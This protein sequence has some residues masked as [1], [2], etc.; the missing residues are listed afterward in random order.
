[1]HKKFLQTLRVK[2][3]MRVCLPLLMKVA[4]ALLSLAPQKTYSACAVNTVTAVDGGG[5]T[6]AL[7]APGANILYACCQGS[8]GADC[9]VY[10]E[11]LDCAITALCLCT[12]ATPSYPIYRSCP[13]S[14]TPYIPGPC[15][16]PAP[17][18][19]PTAPTTGL[20]STTRPS[21][22]P[23]RIPSTTPTD[24]PSSEPTNGPTV[25]PS[26]ALSA[27]SS[28][29]QSWWPSNS[30]SLEP[31]DTPTSLPSY[32][33]TFTG[34]PTYLPSTLA[35]GSGAPSNSP[36]DSPTV[37]GGV[38]AGGAA[39][40]VTLVCLV[41]KKLGWW[42]GED[43]KC[44]PCRRKK[45]HKNVDN[46]DAFSESLASS[47]PQSVRS[48][49]YNSSPSRSDYNDEE[50]GKSRFFVPSEIRGR[51][52]ESMSALPSQ[53]PHSIAEDAAFSFQRRHALANN[54]VELSVLA[55]A[56]SQRSLPSRPVYGNPLN[57]EFDER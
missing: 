48:V 16:S 55:G 19:L 51:M 57:P 6:I 2:S 27:P 15:P 9:Q 7:P 4:I 5:G 22:F 24:E 26:A 52:D 10:C 40:L 35:I 18:M 20:P 14:M 17:T 29:L 11:D 44:K 28:S 38:G 3:G 37:Q 50:S 49:S 23:S 36:W 31:T 32:V 21:L 30:P 25:D 47:E 34:S 42:C 39:L 1:M 33:H 43:T 45:S 8:S 53:G 54:G 41:G 12:T 56:D 13:T 46:D